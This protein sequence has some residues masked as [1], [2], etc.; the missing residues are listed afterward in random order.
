MKRV[1]PLLTIALATMVMHPPAF[2]DDGSSAST[3]ELDRIRQEMRKKKTEISRASRKERS[4]LATIEKIDR[5]IQERTEELL[6]QQKRL[7][8]SE[9]AL[10]QIESASAQISRELEGQKKAYGMR[11]RALYKMRRTGFGQVYGMMGFGSSGKEKRYLGIIADRDRVLIEDYHHA[12]KLLIRQQGEILEKKHEIIDHRHSVESK[13][14]EQESIRREKTLLLASVR[15]K[16]GLYEQTF[17]ELEEASASLWSMIKQD[18]DVRRTAKGQNSVGTGSIKNVPSQRT[19]GAFPWPVEGKVLTPFGMQRHPQFGT[20]VFRRGIEIQAHEGEEVHAME[21]GVVAYADWY[22]GYGKLLILDHGDGFYSLYGN[23][24]RLHL[25]KGERVVRGQIIGLA[26][27][28]GS[29]KG[30]KLYFEIRRNG[31]A[32][33]PLGWLAKR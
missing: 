16:K 2:G 28:T 32:Q 15:Q 9:S 33:D 22:R 11:L 23:L 30:S 21:G 31:E 27:E 8:E 10:S 12:L 7:Q 6:D 13:K 19:K 29:L 1:L 4:V 18:E 26:G 14:T 20:L 5:D 3:E 24:S 25:T 17:H